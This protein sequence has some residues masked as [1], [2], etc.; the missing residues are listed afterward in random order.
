M[1]VKNRGKTIN[2][3]DKLDI[4]SRLEKGEQIVYV[5]RNDRYAHISLSTNYGDADRITESAKTGA[6]VFV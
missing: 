3:E 2:I 6:N 1:Y 4:I 5:F